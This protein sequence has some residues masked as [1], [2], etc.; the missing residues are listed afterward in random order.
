M[1]LLRD[2]TVVV[3]SFSD[4]PISWPRYQ[5]IDKRGGSGLLLA[6]DLVKAVWQESA[7]AI[8]WWWGVSEGTIWRFR[9]ALGVTR[10][11]CM[12]SRRLTQAASKQGLD[13]LKKAWKSLNRDMRQACQ[14][15]LERLKKVAANG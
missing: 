8:G 13:S 12:R 1:C 10:T 3:T 9:K 4:A 7:T 2:C 14:G 15:D 6:G 5:P 11:N